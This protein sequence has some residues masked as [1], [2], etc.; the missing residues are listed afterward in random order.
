[1]ETPDISGSRK[2]QPNPLYLVPRKVVSN[3]FQN[4]GQP[5]QER[6]DA[7]NNAIQLAGFKI[8]RAIA[9]EDKLVIAGVFPE[10]ELFYQFFAELKGC[11]PKGK[12]E[13]EEEAVRQV[14]VKYQK[15]NGVNGD[16]AG[17]GEP[18]K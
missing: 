6:A 5:V 14:I 1:M 17:P 18:A 7:L 13:L 12:F 4:W 3:F 9:L 15:L 16:I 2:L 11:F 8:F 10:H